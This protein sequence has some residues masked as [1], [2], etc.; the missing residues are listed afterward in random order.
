MLVS[1]GVAV[2]VAVR[3]G[4]GGSGE[5]VKVAVG[6]TGEDVNVGGTGVSVGGSGEDVK[7]AVGVTGVQL[8]VNVSVG[9]RK[10]VQDGGTVWEMVGVGLCVVVGVNVRVAVSRLGVGDAPLTEGIT[11]RVGVTVVVDVTVGVGVTG[12]VSNSIEARPMQ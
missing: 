4:V 8:G 11:S 7:V 10:G 9:G 6:G 5:D 3:V 2:R 1:V 12:V